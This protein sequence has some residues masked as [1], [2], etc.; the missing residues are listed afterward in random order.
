MSGPTGKGPLR[1]AIEDFLKSFGFKDWI[2]KALVSL[3]ADNKG[4]FSNTQDVIRKAAAP[5][6]QAAL[7]PFNRIDR[8]SPSDTFTGFLFGTVGL[9][10]TVWNVFDVTARPYTLGILRDQN[11]IFPQER[12]D[13]GTMIEAMDRDPGLTS[14]IHGWLEEAG[15][16]QDALTA[17]E[18]VH[19]QLLGARDYLEAHARGTL[20]DADLQKKLSALSYRPDDIDTLRANA[21]QLLNVAQAIGLS[22]RSGSDDATA[23]AHGLDDGITA[24]YL[25]TMKS[26]SY[27]ET[28]ARQIW[29]TSRSLP[30][31]SQAIEMRA[32]LRPDRSS[33]PFTDDD[34]DY[35]LQANGVPDQYR[36]Q[37]KAIAEPAYPRLII[38]GMYKAGSMTA[39]EVLQA[40]QDLGY[41]GDRAQKIAAYLTRDAKSDQ[42]SLSRDA[43]VNAYKRGL[44]ARS[45]AYDG[46]IAIGLPADQV[47]FYLSLADYDIEAQKTDVQLQVI[48]ARYVNGVTDET[49]LAIELGRLNLPSERMTALE[50][51]WNI[52][53]TNKINIPSRS[54]LDDL[55]RRDIID[56][57]Q[58]R[59]QIARDGYEQGTIDNFV[60]RVDKII[61]DDTAAEL[62][63]QQTEQ[64][65]LSTATLRTSYQVQR[66]AILVSIA[67]LNSAIAD[68]TLAQHTITD[69]AELLKLA[70]NITDYKNQI[71]HYQ[72]QLATLYQAF[73]ETQKEITSP[74]A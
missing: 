18:T 26:L 41:R 63:A 35:I 38:A 2:A 67:H 40:V 28:T 27:D 45:Q 58:Y 15:I 51:I 65:R 44:Y 61:A 49:Q 3:F 4:V 17:L 6:A 11:K 34:L 7:G 36:E 39:D 56:H 70:S 50:E 37:L 69:P 8:L 71:V 22:Q 13:V 66:S 57:T 23:A 33:V 12:P 9:I 47:E 16:S 74:N 19:A 21:P 24:D 72:E 73:L 10:K 62:A 59:A 29:R 64:Q 20:T 25:A 68:I 52:Q 14:L 55:L 5:D 53:R 30:N 43:I 54:E 1:I 31:L 42:Q 60:V 46:L 48:Q 32:R